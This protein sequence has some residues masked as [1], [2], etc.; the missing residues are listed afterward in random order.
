LESTG[1]RSR[2]YSGWDIVLSGEHAGKYS[3]TSS[4]GVRYEYCASVEDTA[5]GREDFYCNVA[6]V[7][8]IQPEESIAIKETKSW[9]CGLEGCVQNE[10]LGSSS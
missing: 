8:E 9:K 4:S 7:I 10:L 6:R 3:C 2:C 5:T 1:E